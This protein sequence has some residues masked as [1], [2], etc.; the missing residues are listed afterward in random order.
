[1]G[2]PTEAGHEA[3]WLDPEEALARLANE[4]ERMALRRLMRAGLPF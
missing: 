4:G 3:V 1:M 2:P